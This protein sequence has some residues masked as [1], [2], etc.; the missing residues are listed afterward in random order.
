METATIFLFL[1][2]TLHVALSASQKETRFAGRDVSLS[3]LRQYALDSTK[4]S[5]RE[6]MAG[7][8]ELLALKD[9][10]QN[11]KNNGYS[12]ESDSGNGE[13]SAGGETDDGSSSSA[14]GSGSGSTDIP[15]AAEILKKW[16]DEELD[17][18]TTVIYDCEDGSET[19]GNKSDETAILIPHSQSHTLDSVSAATGGASDRMKRF[20]FGE[21]D[22]EFVTNSSNF[23][24]CAIARVTTGCTGFFIGPYHALTAAHCVN[25]FRYGWKG[26]IRMLRERNCHERGFRSTCSRVFAVLG[27]T[28]Y[29]LYEYDYA[30]VEMDRSGDPA[31]C[32]FGIGYINPWKYPSRRDLE[33]LGYPSDK[34]WY[35]GQPECRYEAMWLAS[36]N[37]SYSVHQNLI[38]WCDVLSGNSGSPV[39]SDTNQNKIVYGIHAQSVGRYVDLEDGSRE[40]E[41]LWNQG[42]MITPLRYFQILRWMG[43][44]QSAE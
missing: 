16:L 14:S 8:E 39:F 18:M 9:T 33:A 2:L 19:I 29:K 5:M 31:P 17:R 1:V 37:T 20:L 40:I 38:Q 26:K 15:S 28:H 34:R 43:L 41:E 12:Y 36:C 10:A 44:L 32:W 42:P 23:P 35:N 7:N 27:H 22:R 3:L 21:D 6:R 24:Q 4:S 13:E 11:V 25:N 30:L